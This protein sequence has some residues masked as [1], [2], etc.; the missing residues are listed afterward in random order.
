[1]NQSNINRK[2]QR[3]VRLTQLSKY[4]HCTLNSLPNVFQCS[5]CKKYTNVNI[6]TNDNTTNI[7]N[8][9]QTNTTNTNSI[10]QNCS[11]CN[12]P[13]YVY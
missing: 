10:V 1:M 5:K 8:N 4:N 12:N 2:L 7:Q 3:Q 11:Y 13:C 6:T 9:T